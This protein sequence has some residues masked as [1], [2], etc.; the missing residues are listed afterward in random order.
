MCAA[1]A[2]GAFGFDMVG[3]IMLDGKGRVEREGC[4]VWAGARSKS[5]CICWEI[6]V[7]IV[8]IRKQG[9]AHPQ[10][11]AQ[12]PSCTRLRSFLSRDSLPYIIYISILESYP[13]TGYVSS[14]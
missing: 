4:D 13:S 12:R 8:R 2:A 5:K 9:L 3:C 11:R 6:H 14:K 10:A 7:R 1:V